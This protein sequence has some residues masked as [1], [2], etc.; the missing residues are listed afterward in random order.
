MPLIQIQQDE[1]IRSTVADS[2]IQRAVYSATARLK[3]KRSEVVA[4]DALP[5]YQELRTQANLI[6][7][8]TLENLDFY[9]EEFEKNLTAN[10]GKLIWA[11]DG[12]EVADFILGLAK[13]R[14][15]L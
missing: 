6:K 13:E 1:K 3:E 4:E 8:H 10:G 15:A 12:K 11:R 2:K 9:L 14:G 7:K 5:E